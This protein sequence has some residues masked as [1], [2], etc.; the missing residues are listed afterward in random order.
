L[1][2]SAWLWEIGSRREVARL[3]EKSG[4]E[5]VSFSPNGRLLAT[6]SE[7]SDDA[8]TRL[9]EVPGG[10]Q[11]ANFPSNTATVFQI[12]FSPDGKHLA[13]STARV[14][15]AGS[16]VEIAQLYHE[17]IVYGV[18]FSPDGRFLATAGRD[19]AA[20]IWELATGQELER[21]VLG[22]EVSHVAFSPDGKYLATSSDDTARLW[23]WRRDD[24]LAEA[25]A[26]L[27]R[28]LSQDE[29]RQFLGAEPYRKTCP[30]LP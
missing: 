19:G 8:G 30:E 28:N 17:G 6:G 15:D 29:W 2:N 10:R 26:R 20:R 22:A 9:W 11:V 23:L 24:L 14:L 4:V 18:A 13:D 1:K 5:S 3:A 27:T 12:V 21:L 25:C 16:G 7:S